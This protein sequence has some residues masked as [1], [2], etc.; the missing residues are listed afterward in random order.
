MVTASVVKLAA[1]TANGSR[2]TPLNL[3]LGSTLQWGA[4]RGLLCLAT[5]RSLLRFLLYINKCVYRIMA[6]IE[7]YRRLFGA[8]FSNSKN[9]ARF[10]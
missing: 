3:S 10:E 2:I 4:G 1:Y 8:I 7:N 6:E 9:P 5:L